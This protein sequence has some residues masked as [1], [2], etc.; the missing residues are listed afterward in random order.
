MTLAPYA[1]RRAARVF[2]LVIAMV[3]LGC[4]AA[5]SPEA[6]APAN[7][8]AGASAGGRWHVLAS[9][10]ELFLLSA[11]ARGYAMARATVA[12]ND[13]PRVSLRSMLGPVEAE[14][15]PQNAPKFNLATM[16]FVAGREKSWSCPSHGADRHTLCVACM[17]PTQPLAV[18]AEGPLRKSA[19]RDELTYEIVDGVRPAGP[20]RVILEEKRTRFVA[21]EVLPDLLYAFRFV[22]EEEPGVELISF[23]LPPAIDIQMSR[24]APT[25]PSGDVSGAFSRATFPIRRGAAETLR[26][27]ITSS[28]SSAWLRGI[29]PS[30][31]PAPKDDLIIGVEVSQ[32]GD[33]PEP[34]IVAYVSRIQ[35]T[36]DYSP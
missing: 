25:E 6:E 2:A 33:E 24:S 16:A 22:N 28:A 21:K 9:G 32:A 29:Y 4:A 10:I 1:A 36:V 14:T 7:A 3:S 12:I 27:R 31:P 5:P 34:R 26:A 15:A 23:I 18:R 19:V 11:E 17:N 35:P 20:S 8:A 30:P 13:I